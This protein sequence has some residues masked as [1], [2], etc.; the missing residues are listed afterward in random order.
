M[1]MVKSFL[2]YPAHYYFSAQEFFLQLTTDCWKGRSE[3]SFTL[4]DGDKEIKIN[5]QDNIGFICH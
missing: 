2:K 4:E 5:V 3:L 1:T